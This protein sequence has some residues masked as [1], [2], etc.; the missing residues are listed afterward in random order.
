MLLCQIAASEPQTIDTTA[1]RITIC[2]Q[3][4]AISAKGSSMTRITSAKAPIFEA[5]ARKAVIGVG[6][7]W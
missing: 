3:L 5:V 2:R 4:S 7:P 1:S 6:A